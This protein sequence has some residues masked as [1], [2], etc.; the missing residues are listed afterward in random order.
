[1]A[2]SISGYVLEKP[3]VG[4]ANNI[5]TATPDN[6]IAD[7]AAWDAAYPITEV[8]PNDDYCTIVTQQGDVKQVRFGWTKNETV[9]RFDYVGRSQRYALLAGGL[10]DVVGTLSTDSNTKRLKVTIP[11]STDFV[12]FPV[13]ISVSNSGSGETFTVQ[14]V[15]NEA[16]FYTPPAGTVQIAMATGTLNWNPSDLTTYSGTTVAFQ[17]Q[18]FQANGTGELGSPSGILLLSPIPAHNQ[19]PWIRLGFDLPLTAIECPNETAFSSDP[20]PGTVEW[21]LNTGR[22]KFNSAATKTAY[23]EGVL[24]QTD[25]GLKY[26][27]LGTVNLTAP[28]WPLPTE[29]GDVV[30]RATLGT[31]VKQFSSTVYVDDF[32]TVSSGTVQVRRVDGALAFSTADVAKYG[33]W[34]LTAYICDL[35]IEHG[36]WLRLYRSPANPDATNEDPDFRN[37]YYADDETLADPVIGAPFVFLPATPLET[38]PIYVRV[39]QGTGSFTSEAFP[40]LA[41]YTVTAPRTYGYLLDYAKG[42]INFAQRRL[43]YVIDRPVSGSY[44]QLPDQYVQTDRLEIALEDIVPGTWAPLDLNT[45]AFL[46]PLSGVVTFTKTQGTLITGGTTANLWGPL[47]TDPLGDFST[48][49]PFDLCYIST[50]STPDTVQGVYTV[51]HTSPTT[52]LLDA[53]ITDVGPLTY[54]VRRGHEVLADRF[55]KD[56]VLQDPGT[57]VERI[58]LLGPISNDPARLAVPV[59]WLSKFRIRYGKERFS[60]TP[61]QV[62]AF[63]DPATMV[64][65]AVEVLATGELNFAQVDLDEGASVYWARLLTPGVDY[66]VTAA[67]GFFEFTERMLEG[68]EGLITYQSVNTDTYVVTSVTERLRFLIRKEQAQPRTT[69]TNSVQFNTSAREVADTPAPAIFRGGRPQ[70]AAQITVKPT[71][72]A[73]DF[74]PDNH[75]EGLLPHG[76]RV[77]LEEVVYVDYYVYGAVGGE[78][79]ATVLQPPMSVATIRIDE[80]A[81]SFQ[82]KGDWLSTFKAGYILR[83]DAAEVHL[84][85]SVTFDIVSGYTVVSLDP[86][87]AFRDSWAAPKVYLSSGPTP[88][89]GLSSYFTAEIG[90]FEAA[91]RGSNKLK[92]HGDKGGAYQIGTVIQFSYATGQIA[93]SLVLGVAYDAD[94]DLTVVTLGSNVIRQCKTGH[95]TLKRTIRPILSASTTTVKTLLDPVPPTAPA[96]MQNVLVY[97]KLPGE[98]GKVITTTNTGNNYYDMNAAG[99]ISFN[100]ALL[101]EQSWD[102][103]YTGYNIVEANRSVRATYTTII[104]PDDDN[105]LLRQALRMSYSTFSPDTFYFRVVKMADYRKELADKYSE[106]V[107]S[108]VPSSGPMLSNSSQAQLPEQGQPS[109]FFPEGDMENQDVVGRSTLKFYNDAVNLLEDA[110]QGMDGRIVGGQDGRILFDGNTDNPRVPLDPADPFEWAYVTNQIDDLIKVTDAPYRNDYDPATHTFSATPLGTYIQAYEYSAWSRFYPN[111]RRRYGI[112]NPGAETGDAVMDTGSKNLTGVSNLRTRRAW[113]V[114][115]MTAEVGDDT[116]EVDNATGSAETVRPPFKVGMKVIVQ[117][118]DLTVIESNG[119]VTGV[120]PTNITLAAPLTSAAPIG[121]TIYRAPDDT[122]GAGTPDALITYVAGR[123]YM[124]NSETGQILYVKPYFPFDGTSPSVPADLQ[125]KPLPA[126]AT[127]SCEVTLANQVMSPDKFP[128]LYGGTTDDDGEIA[129]PIFSPSPACELGAGYLGNDANYT[130]NVR[131]LTTSEVTR[132]GTLDVSKKVITLD[133]ALSI[134]PATY[135]LVRIL[136]GLNGP[137]SF[138]HIQS[139]TPTSITVGTPFAHVDS[140]FNVEIVAPSPLGSGTGVVTLATV[141]TDMV[142]LFQSWGVV[143]GHTVVIPSGPSAGRRLQVTQVISETEL[144]FVMPLPNGAVPYRIVNPLATF[145]SFTSAG[146]ALDTL[147]TNNENLIGVVSRNTAPPLLSE[148]YAIEQ[149]FD[150]VFTYLVDSSS[151]E[152]NATTI[153]DASATFVT[154]KVA[155][156]DIVY[157]RFKENAGMYAVASVTGETTLEIDG[158]FPAD[159]P[160]TWYRIGRPFGTSIETLSGLLSILLKGDAFVVDADSFQE[161]LTTAVPVVNLVGGFDITAFARATLGDDLDTRDAATTNRIA[162]LKGPAGAVAGVEGTLTAGDHFYDRRYTWIDSRIGVLSGTKVRKLRAI[163]ERL[164]LQKVSLDAMV[165]LK[166]I[167]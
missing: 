50:E 150:L 41:T 104:T 145:G 153:V 24:L 2:F 13:R 56:V 87:D 63:S 60:S 106:E 156:G 75:I 107:K 109:T 30:F 85:D 115:T 91:P 4:T 49:Q 57:K 114:T 125:A 165:K 1:M 123:D 88:L 110:L 90:T 166:A 28:L 117:A 105:G 29:G 25:L 20:L 37:V 143:P 48:V 55:F 92:F 59:A 159:T 33:T 124:Y 152:M 148:Q 39:L 151:G 116:L 119:I 136:D 111:W 69:T 72:G 120:L 97:S 161:L 138:Y 147:A 76:D 137:S 51:L 44:I 54:E 15:P 112:V 38:L 68:E 9:R 31:D 12:Q 46:E 42:Q 162:Y 154:S 3:R 66:K 113:A 118:R 94:T 61:V 77:G 122:F 14:A 160:W 129:L 130:Q 73:I 146:T 83:I 78:N 74:L 23:Y 34:V 96:S 126:G 95:V 43:D 141:L 26:R 140:G 22:L 79:T 82:V 131:D 35:E 163:A 149:F 144:H 132:T 58:V 101:P 11:V 53:G 67:L 127:L 167:Q 6:F 70:A 98:R 21:A 27:D 62:T 81:T 47:L 158:H 19:F 45:D 86:N 133:S 32:T 164:R 40:N 89:G 134:I 16:A 7:Q 84:I 99:R 5:Y 139:A 157:I 71:V 36:V 18:S 103:L 135:D 10:P 93:Y 65:G 80:D 128:A 142:A 64:A 8:N 17:R 121:S 155:K 52:L 102:I 108:S 100:N